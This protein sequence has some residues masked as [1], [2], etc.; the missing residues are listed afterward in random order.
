MK[1]VDVIVVGAGFAGAVAARD[2]AEAG[3]SV[4]V[5]EGRDRLGGRTWYRQF[6]G[7]E[8]KL[9][10]G[11]TWIAPDQQPFVKAEVERYGLDLFQSPTYDRYAWGIG[12]GMVREP[13]PF[14]PE[15]W[16]ALERIIAR[17]DADSD[18]IKLFEEPLGQPGL[19]DLD[20]P[21][22]EYV[23]QTPLPDRVRDFILAW[24]TFYF[25]AYPEKLSALHVLSWNTGFGS[26]TGWYL[27]LV[28]K[29]TGGTGR[30]VQR[31]LEDQPVEVRYGADVAS[32]VDSG[33]GA[34][35]E[36][37]D[38][39]RFSA[40]SVI[41]TAPINTWER[42]SFSPELPA[43]HRAMAAEKQAGESVKVW[44]LVPQQEEGNLFGVGM[45]TTFKWIASEYTTEEGTYLCC[46]ASAEADL[47]GNDPEAVERA[48]QE[49]LPGVPVL[50]SDFHDWNNDEFSNGTWMAY[51]PGQVMAHS[52]ALQQPHGRVFFG[53]SDL[54]SG[55]AG[56]IDGAIESGARAAR[57]SNA[58]LG[59]AS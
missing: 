46:F 21:F 16:P 42:V 34:V 12:G 13:F 11:G 23:D 38:G 2:S 29:I 58:L 32:I 4:L 20:I 57:Q 36:T 25:G 59:S 1:S 35:V 8:Q 51:R 14:R 56:W 47:D 55:W 24:P 50:A 30:L 18:R 33:D 49:F 10:I 28:D 45:H 3:H 48:V 7:K 53:N 26:A 40:K 41:V 19:E 5:L 27:L 54:A 44:A 6:A 31:I 52:A 39:E 9:E 22:T 37:R 15:E 43:S 17:I